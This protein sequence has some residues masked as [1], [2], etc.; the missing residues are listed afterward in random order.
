MDPYQFTPHSIQLEPG[1][2]LLLFTDGVYEARSPEGIL[3]GVDRLRHLFKK[4]AREFQG[5]EVLSR[6]E[7]EVLAH[8]GGVYTDDTTLLSIRYS[9]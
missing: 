3:F 9:A 2:H 8:T 6:I 1:D 4:Y 5:A 7:T